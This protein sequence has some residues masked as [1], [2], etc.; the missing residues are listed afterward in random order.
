MLSLKC[1]VNLTT[2]PAGDF[3][4]KLSPFKHSKNGPSQFHQAKKHPPTCILFKICNCHELGPWLSQ[5]WQI[6]MSWKKFGTIKNLSIV[7]TGD[8]S[9]AAESRDT[10]STLDICSTI[11]NL[12]VWRE[13]QIILE[14]VHINK[15]LYFIWHASATKVK[16]LSNTTSIENFL[17]K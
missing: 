14:N 8:F 11:D 3:G 4:I 10:T 15:N 16:Q 5:N 1:P 13:C 9:W 2:P 7:Y 6:R 17:L 12:E